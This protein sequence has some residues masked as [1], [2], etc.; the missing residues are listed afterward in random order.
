MASDWLLKLSVTVEQSPSS[1]VI[2]DINANIEYV[3]PAFTNSTGYTLEEVKGQNPRILKSN[4]TSP[5]IYAEMWERL[6]NGESWR[7]ELINKKARKP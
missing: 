5:E 2:T 7:G 3:N 4:L 6:T 1:I